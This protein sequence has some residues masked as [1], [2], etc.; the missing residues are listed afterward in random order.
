MMYNCFFFN[1]YNKSDNKL[2]DK[3]YYKLNKI[4][5]INLNN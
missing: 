5:N 1:L 3:N 2:E 4:V